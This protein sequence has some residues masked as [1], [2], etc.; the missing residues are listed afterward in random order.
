MESKVYFKKRSCLNLK[1]INLGLIGFGTV[2]QGVVKILRENRKVIE[3]RLGAVLDLKKIA[4]IDIETPRAVKVNKNILTKDAGEILKDPEIDIVIELIGGLE[5]A[6]TF[7]LEAFNNNKHVVTANK[8]LLAQHGKEIFSKANE[9]SSNIGFEASVGGGI[10]IIRS[11]KEG[12]VANNFKSI[13]GIINGTGNYILTK[14]TDEGG[15]FDEVLKE[16]KEKGYAETDPTLDIEGIDSAHKIVILASIAFGTYFPLE[17]VY[18]E[19]I[20]K[21]TPMD[22]QYA[23]ELGYKIKLLAIA[24]KYN[25]KIDVRVHPTMIPMENPISKV[26]GVLNAIYT[27]GDVVGE[28]IFIGRGAGSLPT[29]SAIVGDIVDISR[30]LILGIEKKIR[31]PSISY[32]KESIRPLTLMNIKEVVSEYYLRFSVLDKPGVLSK[33]S[34]VLGNH[35]I[36]I[37]SV[38][39]KGRREGESVPLVM[40]THEAREENM[41][42]ALMKIDKLDVVADKTVLIRVEKGKESKE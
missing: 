38:I 9:R 40:M 4:D 1:I 6:R 30:E 11:L 37:S 29:G 16:A 3:E 10:P 42:S 33:I 17:R 35:H 34:G 12:L 15:K 19:G 24:K 31:V 41:Q 7:I 26:D 27:T 18:T 20:T 39:Q 23:I 2:G 22:I 25:D 28:N 32:R 13:Y 36:S 14:M 8:A 21:I 5:P